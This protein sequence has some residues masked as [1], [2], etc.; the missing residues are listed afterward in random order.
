MHV[1]RPDSEMN[2]AL[3]VTVTRQWYVQ[4]EIMLF[5]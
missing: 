3:K 1:T 5:G 2:V 4:T